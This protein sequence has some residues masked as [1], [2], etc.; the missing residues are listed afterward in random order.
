[1]Y[2]TQNTLPKDESRA[3]DGRW[4]GKPVQPGVYLW[5]LELLLV[6]G[7]TENLSGSVTVVR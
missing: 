6:D 5:Q 2:E 1:M 3:W 7:R 4:K